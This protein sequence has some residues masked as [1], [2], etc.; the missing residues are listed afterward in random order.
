M[1]KPDF[2]YPPDFVFFPFLLTIYDY[3]LKYDSDLLRIY[4]YTSMIVPLDRQIVP[5]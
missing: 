4:R 2:L 5:T 1:G 3:L